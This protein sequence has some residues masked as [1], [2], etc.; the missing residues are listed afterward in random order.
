VHH[1]ISSSESCCA[2]TACAPRYANFGVA[3]AAHGNTGKAGWARS[4]EWVRQAVA[5]LL[6][7]Y[8]F[9][10]PQSKKDEHGRATSELGSMMPT[11]QT[12]AGLDLLYEKMATG[13]AVGPH[14]RRR[15]DLG[16]IDQ[17]KER[18]G[19]ACSLATFKKIA[20]EIA[21]EKSCRIIGLQTDHNVCKQDKKH[22]QAILDTHRDKEREKRSDLPDEVKV[23]RLQK[24]HDEELAKYR[25][26]MGHDWSLRGCI[27]SWTRYGQA[28]LA[29][30]LQIPVEQRRARAQEFGAYMTYVH[31]DD[32][33]DENIPNV[34]KEQSGMLYKYPIK[35]HGQHDRIDN[36]GECAWQYK[37]TFSSAVSCVISQ[38]MRATGQ[39]SDVFRHAA[40]CYLMEPGAGSTTASCIVDQMFINFTT[41]VREQRPMLHMIESDCGPLQLN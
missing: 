8:Y 40:D 15:A 29:M 24:L 2:E 32:R 28:L 22:E 26:H 34:T 35:V 18:T 16:D 30:Y 13:E 37:L 27:N 31:V 3:R 7:I 12:V 6:A 41:R 39:N 10:D 38:S 19:K 9:A 14:A 4:E 11:N 21:L 5:E 20:H 17:W 33:S 25:V 36:T 23:Q 1:I